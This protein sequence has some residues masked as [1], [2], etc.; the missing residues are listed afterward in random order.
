MF[1][2]LGYCIVVSD[3]VGQYI[4]YER[5][6]WGKGQVEL[7]VVGGR[8]FRG[9]RRG[10]SIVTKQGPMDRTIHDG[11][12]VS[13][14]L[15]TG[16]RGDNTVIKVLT[17]THS[18]GVPIGRISHAGLSCIDNNTARRNVITF[19]TTGSCSAISSVLRCTRDENR[20][21]FII[22]LSRIRSPRGLNTVVEATRYTKIRKVVVPGHEDTNLDCAITGTSTNTVRCVHI[23]EIAGV[24]I[25]LSRL[26]R[27][28]I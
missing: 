26:G 5:G 9:A 2:G 10:P 13:G 16:N 22:I 23:T 27:G 1:G 11:H 20:T 24:T 6:G 21:P 15:I 7:V 17:G 19:T 18:G 4:P 14:V 25:A 3:G 8:E 28:N 12:P